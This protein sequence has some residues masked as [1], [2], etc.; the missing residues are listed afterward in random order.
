MCISISFFLVLTFIAALLKVDGRLAVQDKMY[1]IKK[2]SKIIVDILKLSNRGN[3][4]I[5]ADDFFPTL[6]FVCLKA[7]PSRIQSNLN[8]L[9]RFTNDSKLSRGEGGYLFANLV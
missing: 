6:V 5:S 8:F 3:A 7:N 1:Y 2:C 4:A 9:R